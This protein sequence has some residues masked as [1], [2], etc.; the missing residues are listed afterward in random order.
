MKAAVVDTTGGGFTVQDVD[1]AEPL[2]REVLVEVRASGLCHTDL[3][4]AGQATSP[5]PPP[6]VLGHEIAGVVTAVGPHATEF[7]AGDHVVGCLVQ[8][9]GTCPA[10]HD[11]RP[12][13]C[14]RPE[15]TLRD[16][17]RH[18]LPRLS[19]DG[20]RV[21]QGMGLGGF[22]QQALVHENQLTAVPHRLPPAPAALLG[23]AVLTGAGSVLNAAR[24]REGDTVA[25]IG[26]GGVGL[27]TIGAAGRAGASRIVAVDIQDV[28][29]RR[30]RAFGA[31]DV[32]NS[33]TTNAVSAVRDLT[34]GGVRH[35]F[36]IV[37]TAATADRALRMTAPGGDVYV[38]GLAGG[39]TGELSLSLPRL[40]LQQKRIQGLIMGSATP[41]RDIAHYAELYLRGLLNLDDLVS[42]RI[43][44]DEIDAGYAALQDPEVA[45]VVVTSF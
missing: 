32:V 28:R 39:D 20:R 8:W 4:L 7:T 19:R 18:G 12:Y 3:T 11:D 1:I 14:R 29:L 45:R 36:D 34:G 24:V 9:C 33:T 38:V 17:K 40:L 35:A 22:A 15:T 21:T 37:G 42:R 2:G 26:T 10:C 31:T 44:L 13:Q 43:S 23:C 30:A 5:Y 27:N 16:P 25:V 41:R 6:V